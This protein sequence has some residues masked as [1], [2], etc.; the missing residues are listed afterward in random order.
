MFQNTVIMIVVSVLFIFDTN[1]AA[2]R[3]AVISV[4]STVLRYETVCCSG[5]SGSPPNCQRKSVITSSDN[6]FYNNL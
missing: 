4:T 5:Y 1:R 2:T 6:H 3:N